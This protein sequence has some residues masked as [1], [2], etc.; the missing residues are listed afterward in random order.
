[1]LNQ[2]S[3]KKVGQWLDPHLTGSYLKNE[4]SPQHGG[5]S[6]RGVRDVGEKERGNRTMKTIEMS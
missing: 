1:M 5:K 6:Q 3:G 4:L 2:A